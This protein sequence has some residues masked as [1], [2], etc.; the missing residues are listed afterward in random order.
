MNQN[1]VALLQKQYLGDFQFQDSFGVESSLFDHGKLRHSSRC[2]TLREHFRCMPEIIRFSNNL[3][4]AET[5]LIPLRQYGPDRLPPLDHVFVPGG[6]RKGREN[7]VT[8]QPEAE[9]VAAEI[10]KMCGDNRYDGKS[11]GVIVLQGEAQ[12]KL[13]EQL[14]LKLKK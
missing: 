10:V 12:A 13:I 1:A 5:P 4:Y 11:M 8:N 3:C 2:I 9:A 7:N 6:N 14:L